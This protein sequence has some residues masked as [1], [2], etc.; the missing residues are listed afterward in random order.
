MRVIKWFWEIKT[1]DHW[2][3]GLVNRKTADDE[4]TKS[5]LAKLGN[6]RLIRNQRYRWTQMPE[7][8]YRIDTDDY[9]K[10]IYAEGE[11]ALSSSIVLQL[12]P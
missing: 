10:K 9:R 5:V 1:A 8:R 6:A 4:T 3:S 7:C 12:S 11:G 2:G